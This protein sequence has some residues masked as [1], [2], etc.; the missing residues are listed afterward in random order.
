MAKMA[1]TG[2]SHF[3]LEIFFFLVKDHFSSEMNILS[4]AFIWQ[5][6]IA[7]YYNLMIYCLDG[8]DLDFLNLLVILDLD[9]KNA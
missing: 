4:L 7:Y 3:G 5:S 2:S 6:I 9:N 1:L 8:G